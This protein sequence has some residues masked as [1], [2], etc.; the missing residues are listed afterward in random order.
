MVIFT[1][2]NGPWL[3][4]GDHAGS[5]GGLRE[6]KGTSFEG[7]VRVP[8]VVRWPGQL[9]AGVVC[10][11]VAASIDFVPTMAHLIGATLPQGRVVD[12][13]DILPLLRDPAGAK[14]PHEAY[15]IYWNGDLQ[16]VRSGQ[17]KLHFPH[18]YRHITRPGRDGKPGATTQP[19]IELSLFDLASDPAESQDVAEKYPEVVARLQK[20]AEACMDDLGDARTS[21][22]GKGVRPP[23]KVGE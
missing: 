8:C 4:Y 2:D 11:E 7:G 19:T 17:W 21:R 5:S 18:R 14:S 15:F 3:S 6:G 12:G 16:A 20:L 22:A 23:G 10:R 9:P 1:A 13:K